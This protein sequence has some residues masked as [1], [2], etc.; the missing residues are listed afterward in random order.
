MEIFIL[1]LK[2]LGGLLMIVKGADWLTDGASCIARRYNISSLV[3]GLTIVAFGTSAPELVVSC[4]SAYSGSDGI[5][6]G[7]VIGSNMF[8]TFAII[9]ITAMLMPIPVS[10]SNVWKDI[11]LCILA[12]VVLFIM[13]NDQML[14]GEEKGRVVGRGDGLVLL[15]FFIIF[16][17]YSFSI[18]HQPSSSGVPSRPSGPEGNKPL[19]S[20]GKSVLLFLVGLAVLVVGG[21]VFVDGASG[22]ASKMGV[23]D[24]VI[25]T[26]IVAAGTSFPELFASI[27]AARKGDTAMAV[28]NV[29]GSNIFNVFFILGASS[30]I[31]PLQATSVSLMDYTFFL[32]SAVLLFIFGLIGKARLTISRGEGFV[33][34]MCMVGYYVYAVLNVTGQ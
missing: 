4:L 33:M 17:A 27:A 20:M 7:N 16:M 1:L 6:I 26:T 14:D 9:G 5:A 30:V 13:T 3:I 2:F 31:S 12:S 18:A 25:A 10:K 19:M 11:P 34:L 29:V 32:L 8:N 21:N 23:S 24:A 15:C 22:I 28:G